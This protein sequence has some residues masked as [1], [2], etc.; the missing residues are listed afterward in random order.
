VL[1]V[2]QY[3][4]T[5]EQPGAMRHYAHTHRLAEEGFDVTLITSYVKNA[6]RLV[7]PEYEGKAIVEETDGVLRIYKVY[8]Y[9]HYGSDFVSRMRNYL[10][11]MFYAILAGLRTPSCDIVY[12]SS[13]SLFSGLAGYVLSRIKR[14]AFV[15]EVR[16]LWPQAAVTMGV[17]RS[18]LLIWPAEWLARF[19]YRRADRVIAVTRGINEA[20]VAEGIPPSNVELI[21]NGVDSDLFVP[22]AAEEVA[23]LRREL[24]WDGRFVALYVG[25]LARSDGLETI[26]KAARH[27]G[28]GRHVEFVLLGAGE[29][30]PRLMRLAEELQLSNITFL[31]PQP[32]GRIPLYIQAAD[33]CLL[34]GRKD[35]FF[36]MVLPNKL[37]DYLAAGTPVIASVPPGETQELLE[38]AA[39]GVVVEAERPEA[40]AHALMELKEAPESLR[41]MGENG[42]RYIFQHYERRA[43][44]DKLVG[45][46]NDLGASTRD[47]RSRYQ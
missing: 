15:F 41:A 5:P 2:T 37:F 36:G 24:D 44:A 31:C 26:V 43:L 8:A 25:T 7:P 12:A 39:A 3:Y 1:Y 30:K 28:L 32:K 18:P 47:G 42:R 45:V 14:A 4:S 35:S 13:P 33:V 20:I 9:P 34:P 10:S 46:L 23:A 27:V 38:T 21:T 16:D 11:F 19:L 40:L 22:A 29:E 6:L 17:L